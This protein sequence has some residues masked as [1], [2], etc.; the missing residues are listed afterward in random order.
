MNSNTNQKIYLKVSYEQ[1]DIAKKLGAKWDK[2]NK[3]WYSLDNNTNLEKLKEY[4]YI[5][6]IEELKI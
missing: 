6:Q 2:L 5:N 4:Y 3:S 1:K